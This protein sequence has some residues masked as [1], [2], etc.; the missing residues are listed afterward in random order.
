MLGED[1]T[2]YFFILAGMWRLL[3]IDL[4]LFLWI[5]QETVRAVLTA[6]TRA[7][8]CETIPF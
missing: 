4:N 6:G 3:E 8:V 2:I 7:C 5:S 1:V